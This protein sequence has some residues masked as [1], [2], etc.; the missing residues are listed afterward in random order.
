MCIMHGMRIHTLLTEYCCVACS[1]AAAGTRVSSY[2]AIELY[3]YLCAFGVGRKQTIY[4]SLIKIK[5]C[6]NSNYEMCIALP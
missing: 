1:S 3:A 4:F 2:I 6:E 5:S